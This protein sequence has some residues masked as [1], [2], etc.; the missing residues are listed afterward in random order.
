MSADLA[1]VLLYS[2]DRTVREQVR[3]A[4]GRRVASDVAPLEVLEVATPAAAVRAVD[5]GGFDLCILDAESVP[6]GGM[7]LCRQL[8]SEIANCPPVLLLVARMDDAW[9]ATWSRAEAIS[10]FPVDPI[11]LPRA[12]ADVLRRGAAADDSGNVAPGSEVVAARHVD[13]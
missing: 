10:A 11:R 3:L 9:L 5:A 2:D 8:K 1:R 13:A 7:G 12:V 6:L 4:L